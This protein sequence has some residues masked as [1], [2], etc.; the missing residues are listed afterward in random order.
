MEKGKGI[1][2][3]LKIAYRNLYRNKRRSIMS[4]SAVAVAVFFVIFM[5][6]WMVGMIDAI[7]VNVFAFDTGHLSVATDEYDRKS[8]FA[9]LQYPLE[10]QDGVTMESAIAKLKEVDGVIAVFPR[11]TSYATL[12]DSNVKNAM[13]LGLDTVGEFEHQNFNLKERNNGIVEGRYPT[14][15]ENGCAVGSSLARKLGV[16]VGDKLP[17]KMVSSQ[18]SDKFWSPTVLGIFNYDNMNMDDKFIVVNFE[19]LQ[20]IVTLR[21]TTQRL[22]VYT[23]DYSNTT[24]I[25]KDIQ[26]AM[27]GFTKQPAVVREWK[28][29]AF[30]AMLNQMIWIYYIVFGVFIVLASFLVVNT[31]SM[32]IHERIKE[33]GMMGTIGMTRAQIVAVFFLE[34]VL[35]SIIGAFIGVLVGGVLTWLL[36]LFPIDML[37]M[38]GGIDMPMS[39]TMYIDFSWGILV[40]GFFYGVIIC[41]CCTIFP[42]M[43]SAFIEPVEALRN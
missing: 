41:S 35:L 7:K 30:M 15:G 21:D 36:S 12:L 40:S 24:N 22:I 37:A 14:T 31:I 23:D 10:W 28:E 3:M 26:T 33:I 38:S 17:F 18:F 9:P 27:N 8:D 20:R 39:N 25:K 1:F 4:V 42:S 16:K 11:I 2:Y 6:A 13:V 5:M 43:K 32:I 19:R 34:A 29:N